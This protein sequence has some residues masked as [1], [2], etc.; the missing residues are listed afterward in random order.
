MTAT[1]IYKQAN[2]YENNCDSFDSATIAGS[3]DNTTLGKILALRILADTDP[4]QEPIKDFTEDEI[5]KILGTNNDGEGED[6]AVFMGYD[7]IRECL[8]TPARVAL[9]R[10]NMNRYKV[11]VVDESDEDNYQEHYTAEF[12]QDTVKLRISAGVLNV[13]KC[14]CDKTIISHFEISGT[15]DY[16]DTAIPVLFTIT[17]WVYRPPIDIEAEFSHLELQSTNPVDEIGHLLSYLKGQGYEGEDRTDN[18]ENV[19]ATVTCEYLAPDL[20]LL[21]KEH[22]YRYINEHQTMKMQLHFAWSQYSYSFFISQHYAKLSPD[23]KITLRNGTWVLN[24]IQV[25]A[26]KITADLTVA[27]LNIPLTIKLSPGSEFVIRLSEGEPDIR[28][29]HYVALC[30]CFNIS[31]D[32][33]DIIRILSKNLDFAF[34]VRGKYNDYEFSSIEITDYT[35][36]I[37]SKVRLNNHILDTHC[38]CNHTAYIYLDDLNHNTV[39]HKAPFSF[40]LA[41][42]RA[43]NSCLSDLLEIH[44]LGTYSKGTINQMTKY[45]LRTTNYALEIAGTLVSS[46][47]FSIYACYLTEVAWLI[48]DDEKIELKF[49]HNPEY[50]IFHRLKIVKKYQDVEVRCLH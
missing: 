1:I 25:N 49:K 45:D 31:N 43:T 22:T 37:S 3:F 48:I 42:F 15:L 4:T 30:K 26:S 5:I 44:R 18:R 13:T 27:D 7:I 8:K 16:H 23:F 41:H 28:L 14:S 6:E 50:F 17:M 33:H 47:S 2:E 35:N 24:N 34:T 38:R 20:A 9:H 11:D 21:L 46:A 12:L 10:K 36:E 32:Q 39:V 40:E 29:S 19:H